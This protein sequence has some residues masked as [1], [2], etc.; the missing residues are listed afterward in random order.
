MMFTYH[1]CW[2]VDSSGV[3]V[4]IGFWIGVGLGF[5]EGD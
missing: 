5:I 3:G 2:Y 1:L 4:V